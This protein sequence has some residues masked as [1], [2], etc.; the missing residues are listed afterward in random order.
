MFSDDNVLE[1]DE[2]KAQ[3]RTLLK[4]FRQLYANYLYHGDDIGSVYLHIIWDHAY[5]LIT[6]LPYRSLGSRQ[7]LLWMARL[8]KFSCYT[9]K[10]NQQGAEAAG[11]IDKFD[12]QNKSTGGD[13]SIV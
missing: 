7:S 2:E 10:Y 4:K 3:F 9:A 12:G 6:T 11:K 13:N 8:N 5:D 1:T